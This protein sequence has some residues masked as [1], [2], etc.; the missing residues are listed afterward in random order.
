MVHSVM[1]HN[2][3][4]K[5]MDGGIVDMCSRDMYKN[6][7]DFAWYIAVLTD[8]AC[9]RGSRL[10]GVLAKQ[11][12]DVTLRV[13]AIRLFAVNSLL[14]LLLQP[15]LISESMHDVI[16]GAAWVVGEFSGYLQQ[17]QIAK[18]FTS[19]TSNAMMYMKPE[20]QAT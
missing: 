2:G 12:I 13:P 17:D 16:I 15:E 9:T 14:G 4:F 18:V 6:T 20:I 19:L 5:I 3:P 11:L 10:G 8:L 1:K 7:Q